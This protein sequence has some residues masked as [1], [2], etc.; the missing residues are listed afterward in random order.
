[1][2]PDGCV[3]TCEQVGV[4]GV[5]PGLFGMLQANEVIKGIV[6]FGTLLRDELA[7][8]DLRTLSIT[9]LKRGSVPGC[10]GCAG[11]TSAHSFEFR[12]VGEAIEALGEAVVVD[13]REF[14][15]GP[16][17]DQSHV[18]MPYSKFKWGG[19]D[20]PVLLVCASGVRSV[21]LALQLHEAGHENVYAIH[22][23]LVKSEGQR[24]ES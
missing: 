2:P 23:G 15:E 18:R 21:Q 16:A 4:V 14:D 24:V 7:M 13:I 10:P 6:G 11:S 17:T 1:V 3:D 20:G 19:W 22:E 5:V 9:K 8:I 12:T